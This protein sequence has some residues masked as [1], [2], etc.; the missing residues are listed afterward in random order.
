MTT[1][2]GQLYPHPPEEH[3]RSF[4]ARARSI[5]EQ[6]FSLSQDI[7]NEVMA[8]RSE[9]PPTFTQVATDVK[10]ILDDGMAKISADY[11]AE[12]ALAADEAHGY[13][14]PGEGPDL[15]HT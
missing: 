9:N 5:E 15:P 7:Y 11:L 8:V 6:L 1:P 14:A 4:I 13:P 2:N 10:R 3:E 12:P